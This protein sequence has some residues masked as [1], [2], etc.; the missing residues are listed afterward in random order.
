MKRRPLIVYIDTLGVAMAPEIAEPAAKRGIETA[1]IC[2]H[3]AVTSRAVAPARLIETDDFSLVNIRRIVRRLERTF[4]IRGLHSSF[5]PFRPEGFV[6]GVVATLA[7][8][9]GLSHSPVDA[10]EAATNKYVARQ[11]LH[12]ARVPDIPFGLATDERSLLEAAR[13]IGYP[14]VLKPLTGVGSSLILKC[15]NDAEARKEF[16][17]AMRRLPRAYYDQLRMAPHSVGS[18]RFDPARSMLVER[19]LD[20]REASVECIV[21]G[22]EV[23]PLVVHD[24]LSVEERHGVVLEHLLVSP[25][26]RFTRAEVAAMKRHA[27]AAI[28]ALGLR[29]MFC[30]VELRYV[31]A[32]PRVLEV[33]PRVGGGCITQS[34]QTFTS[35]DVDAARVALI[36]GEPPPPIRRRRAG[37]HAMMLLF[38]PRRGTIRQLSGLQRLRYLPGVR[39]VQTGFIPGDR[40]G[41]DTEEIFLASVWMRAHDEAAARRA[42]ST[43]RDIVSIRVT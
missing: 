38:S 6:H 41:G 39:C 37:R 21:V 19:Y 28:R 4:R 30:H 8:E 22:D 40:V 5:G 31:D 1:V 17:Y 26:S 15:A 3:R 29:D 12:A 25:P 27:V 18:M 24:K 43:V 36:L 35:L 34:I 9:R 13:R 23:I 16:R 20:G 2:P 14:V 42:Y 11:R 32:G 10:L 33:N 7:A